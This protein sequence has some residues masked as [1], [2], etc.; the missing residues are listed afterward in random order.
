MNFL[1]L[2]GL[3]GIFFLTGWLLDQVVL[4]GS[5][6]EP[7]SAVSWFGLGAAVWMG[8]VFALAA[9]QALS[10]PTLGL[11]ALLTL[12]IVWRQR[13][14]AGRSFLDVRDGT[15][16][17]SRDAAA[18]VLGGVL[19]AILG[20][21]WLQAIW[22]VLSWDADVYHLTVPRLYLEHGGF[23]RIP[24]NVYSNWPLNTQMLYVLA[25]AARDHVLAKSVHYA[26]GLATFVLI[27]QSVRAETRAWAA[28][29]AGALFLINPVVLD[30][31]RAAY[32]DLTLAFFLL[33]GF[34]MVH[35]ALEGGV[36]RDRR[37]ILAGVFAG[38]A[39]GIK[40][41]GLMGVFCLLVLF[42][43]ASGR[44]GQRA[45]GL[46]GGVVRILGPA[47][48][49]L[50]PWGLKTW[51]FTGNPVYPFLYSWWGGPEWSREL[52]G[53]LAQWQRGIGM[54]RGWLDYLLLPFRVAAEGGSGYG[55]FDGRIS[56]L[57]LALVPL[58]AFLS[59]GRPLMARSLGV[60]GTYFVLWALS[61]QQMR[62]L[63]PILPL[64]AIAG[65]L[66]LFEV[67][68]RLQ[69]TFQ[70][71]ARWVIA[72]GLILT[73]ATV[74]Q[75]MVVA[76]GSMVGR[77]I[78]QGVEVTRSAIH[79]VFRYIDEEVPKGSK[80]MFL[81][82]NRG[83][84]CTREFIADSFFEASQINDLI[85]GANGVSGIGEILAQHEVT[86]LLIENRDR[87][88]PWPRS[89]F[90]FLNDPSRARQLYR[91]PDNV[92]DEVQVIEPAA[93]GN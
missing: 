35:Q 7:F 33:L 92:Y 63:L 45:A 69:V 21:L 25:L 18:W 56:I 16:D 49:L 68:R 55:H 78:D 14:S 82:T 22:P 44:R 91:S 41:T 57:W 4:K 67:T 83:F 15:S 42:L 26:F 86:H 38:V 81:N 65:A 47:M 2:L 36:G 32:V 61:S 48:L 30:E 34:L 90:D 13:R 51:A 80:L 39:A 75:S 85:Q 50:V 27:W 9:V 79:P 62:F 84:F 53:Q 76:T 3:V 24:F 29:G 59:R 77:Y 19:G 52:G 71:F 43:V 46:L 70:P 89:L 11:V 40:P 64:L 31:F 37:L 6:L 88:V 74:S 20:G 54:G 87:S 73:L 58:A 72:V 23:R 66:A 28:W 5:G 17:S 1:G 60:A 10:A 8:W 12:V 93:G